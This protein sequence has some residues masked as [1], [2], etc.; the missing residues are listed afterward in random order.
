MKALASS[1]CA[2]SIVLTTPAWADVSRDE[3]A[4]AAQRV[5]SG[6]VL[7]IERSEAD[8]RPVWRVKVLTAQGEVRVIRVD[9]ASGRVVG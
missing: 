4:A 8:R 3:A 1:L 2:L 7:S 9:A 6:R 5:A